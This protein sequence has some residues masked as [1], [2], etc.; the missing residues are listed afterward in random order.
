MRCGAACGQSLRT[1]RSMRMH[2]LLSAP[3][4]LGTI[5][6]VVFRNFV[7]SEKDNVANFFTKY[8]TLRCLFCAKFCK[9][10]NSCKISKAML[11]Y[12]NFETQ[13]CQWYG[14]KRIKSIFADKGIGEKDLGHFIITSN[15]SLFFNKIDFEQY[16]FE[17][18]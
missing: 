17:T 12:Q 8:Q 7:T 2:I 3:S 1:Q 9:L 14:V 15:G 6:N 11:D 13:V 10:T 18:I 4:Q 16:L 5:A